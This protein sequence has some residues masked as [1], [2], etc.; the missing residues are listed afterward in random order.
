MVRGVPILKDNLRWNITATYS[1][2]RNRVDNIPG[3]LLTFAGGF[4]QVAAINGQ[5][6]GTF[7]S[8]Y[9]ARNADGSLLLTPGGLPQTEKV[10]RDANGQPVGATLRKVIG[11]PNPDWIGSLI[12]EVSVG[13]HF[14]F[15]AQFDASIGGDVFNFTRRVGDRDLYGGLAGYEPELR[16][17]VPKGTSAALILHF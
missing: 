15:R 3:G 12:N 13:K 8:T 2:N 4:G 11:D 17:E 16:G 9:F 10:G 7:Y 1:R 6:L 5:P 14:T